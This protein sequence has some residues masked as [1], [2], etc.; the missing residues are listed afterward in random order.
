MR[1][2]S[3]DERQWPPYREH[4]TCPAPSRSIWPEAGRMDAVPPAETF[5][6]FALPD[7]GEEEIE[8][9]VEALRSGW[10]TT[11][12]RAAAFEREFSERLGEGVHAVAVN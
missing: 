6:P 10:V 1:D 2:S 9:V 11:G 12:P 3:H 5:L 7:I 8:A 4:S